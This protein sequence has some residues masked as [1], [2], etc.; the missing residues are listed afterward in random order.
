MIEFG[1]GC[2][3]AELRERRYPFS[4]NP[5]HFYQSVLTTTDLKSSVNPVYTAALT[6][7]APELGKF[8]V[9]MIFG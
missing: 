3:E 5:Q 8:T 2:A 1:K 4:P 7:V 6:T 9:V